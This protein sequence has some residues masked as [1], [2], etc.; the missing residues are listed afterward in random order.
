[1]FKQERRLAVWVADA[2]GPWRY[3][4]DYPVLAA[5]GGVGPKLRE[6]DYQ[7]PEGLYATENLNPASSYR[8]SMK[9]GYP[10]AFDR[11]NAAR[12]HRTRLGGD[13]FIHG[14]NVS[15]GCVAMGDPAIE[16]LFTLVAETGIAHTRVIIAARFAHHVRARR[17]IDAALDRA[18]VAISGRGAPRVPDRARVESRVRCSGH[19]KGREGVTRPLRR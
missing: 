18:A 13:V 12:E 5:S 7:V 6:G 2:K 8:L 1:M 10:N 9:V 3:L 14:K 17:A 16:E 11:L 19:E 4:R 15:I